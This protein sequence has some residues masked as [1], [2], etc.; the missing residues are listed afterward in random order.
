MHWIRLTR[1]WGTDRINKQ[2]PTT[3]ISTIDLSKWMLVTNTRA[4][5]WTQL[6][7]LLHAFVHLF[8]SE[9]PVEE[10]KSLW[11]LVLEQF[12]DLLVKILLLAAIIS[13]VSNAGSASLFCHGFVFVSMA[14]YSL[15]WLCIR[16]Y[17][18]VFV[19]MNSHQRPFLVPLTNFCH[20]FAPARF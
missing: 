13:F 17:D 4:L 1:E 20:S 15:P 16:C 2:I 6:Y 5:W 19:A 11:Q 10:G 14:L 8:Q 7:Q 12:D 9:L 3:G 18:F